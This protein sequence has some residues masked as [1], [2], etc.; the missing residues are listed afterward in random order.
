MSQGNRASV[1]INGQSGEGK[2]ALVAP[3]C[4]CSQSPVNAR[5]TGQIYGRHRILFLQSFHSRKRALGCC[6]SFKSTPILEIPL[7]PIFHIESR[8]NEA[9][10][11]VRLRCT[12]LAA[13]LSA[14]VAAVITGAWCSPDRNSHQRRSP[15]ICPHG[16]EPRWDALRYLRAGLKFLNTAHCN[17]N[18]ITVP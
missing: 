14:G 15:E 11:L 2:Q 4:K 8:C 9:R 17:D 5:I 16:G 13:R 3:G 7:R 18:D 6:L 10:V 1:S 12:D